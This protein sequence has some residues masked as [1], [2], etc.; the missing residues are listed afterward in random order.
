VTG[1]A[2][3]RLRWLVLIEMTGYLVGA[4]AKMKK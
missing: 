4:T 2:M 1:F 3:N